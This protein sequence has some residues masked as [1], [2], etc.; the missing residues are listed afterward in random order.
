MEFVIVTVEV[1]VRE[2]ALVAEVPVMVGFFETVISAVLFVV[3]SVLP[4]V[5]LIL[6]TVMVEEPSVVNP[7][8][9]NVP[10][11]AVDTVSVAV[12]PVCAGEEVLYVAV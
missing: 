9:V 7:V 2:H 1:P 8:A 12:K 6:V 3:R 4:Q 5:L 11:P 10:V